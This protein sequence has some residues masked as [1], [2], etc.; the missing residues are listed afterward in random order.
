MS[1]WRQTDRPVDRAVQELNRQI[2][3]VQKQQR[4]LEHQKSPGQRSSPQNNLCSV[5]VDFFRRATAPHRRIETESFDVGDEPL[6]SLEAEPIPFACE[7]SHDLFGPVVPPAATPEKSASRLMQYLSTGSLRTYKPLKS[8][9]R[10]QR[11]R[12]FMWLG[13]SLVALWILYVIVR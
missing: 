2:A 3:A 4:A 8:E 10:R 9:Q 11:N 13:L 5:V 1:Y 7:P 12:F 6:K